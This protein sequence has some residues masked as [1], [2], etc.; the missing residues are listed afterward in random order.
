MELEKTKNRKKHIKILSEKIRKRIEGDYD[1]RKDRKKGMVYTNDYND[2]F[3]HSC[4]IILI[5]ILYPYIQ[6]NLTCNYADSMW[7]SNSNGN[8]GN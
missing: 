1:E 7:D 2:V 4:S 3:E 8:N 5:S 6:G